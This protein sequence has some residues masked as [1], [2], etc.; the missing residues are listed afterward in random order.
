MRF[1]NL[2][3]AY[4][5]SRIYAGHATTALNP[6]PYAYES[7]YAVR[8]TIQRQMAGEPALNA[9]PAKGAVVAPVAL[10]GPY[11]WADGTSPRASD[12]LVWQREDFAPDGTHPSPSGRQKVAAL[13]LRFFQGDPTTQPWYLAAPPAV[14]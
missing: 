12:G 3:L 7:A 14:G 6:E 10:W 8:W 4:L 5:S 11:L 1:P 2:Q 13:L 9:D